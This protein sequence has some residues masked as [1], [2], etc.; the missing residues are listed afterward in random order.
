MVKQLLYRNFQLF[1]SV[2]YE[3]FQCSQVL[4]EGMVPSTGGVV[5]PWV[6]SVFGGGTLVALEGAAQAAPGLL[7]PGGLLQAT[8]SLSSQPLPG[9]PGLKRLTMGCERSV[10]WMLEALEGLPES[11]RAKYLDITG[12]CCSGTGVAPNLAPR[13]CLLSPGLRGDSPWLAEGEEGS[14]SLHH[15]FNVW[16]SLAAVSCTFKLAYIFYSQN[17]HEEASSICKLLCKRLQTAD[18]YACPE[19]PPE[20]VSA[21]LGLLADTGLNQTV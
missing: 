14:F 10:A 17:L 4:P 19:I 6:A 5:R 20:R 3:A 11:E 13:L 8:V 21:C 15:V 1:A 18:A 12:Q 2:T 7:V 16:V 9:W